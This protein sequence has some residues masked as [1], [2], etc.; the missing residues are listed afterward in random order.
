MIQLDGS[1]IF[2]M[3]W[4]NHQLVYFV[5]YFFGEAIHLP[6]GLILHPW[7]RGKAY[8]RNFHHDHI[9][10][11]Y[12]KSSFDFKVQYPYASFMEYVPKFTI[13]VFWM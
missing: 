11:E 13:N 3:G 2:Q 10:D 1:H 9:D 4:F 8:F 5:R 12:L 6:H 7:P